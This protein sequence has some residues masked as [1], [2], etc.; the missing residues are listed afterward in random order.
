MRILITGGAGYIGGTVARILLAQGH[1]IT[2]FDNLCHS[3]RSAVAENTTFIEGDIADRPLIEK[4]L[5]EGRFDGVMNFAALIEAGESMKRPEIYFRNN[6]AATLTLLEAMLATGHDRLVF[7][8]T[9]ACYGEPEKTPILEDARLQPTNPYGE[10]KLLVEHM[11]RW[12]NLIHG[13]KY[14]SL[15]YFNVAG[16]IE[17]YGE[18]H[19]PES[20]LIP[21]ILDVALGRRANIKI[22]GRDYPTQDGTCIRDYIHVRDL[23]EAHLLALQALSDAKSRLIYN[24][25]NGQGFSVLEVIESARRVTGRP[26]AV[27]ECDR[28]PG[29]PAVLVAGSAKIK[30]ELGWVPRFAELD[31][32]MA[33]AW[34]WHQKRYA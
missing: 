24:I 28:R 30:A 4:T 29:D 14:A 6:T 27:E 33:S 10:S 22:F 8:S 3:K 34:E 25:G 12:M 2:V 11:L 18:A 7:S 13:F 19:E 21:L 9:A 20:H 26:I 1:A 5:R 23:A 31:Q 16:A 15:R 17:G 32:I